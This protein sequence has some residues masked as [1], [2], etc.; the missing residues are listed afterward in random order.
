M[1]I[2]IS[3]CLSLMMMLASAA[4]AQQLAA[5]AGYSCGPPAN[6]TVDVGW[7]Q[8]NF[9]ECNSGY[10]PYEFILSPATVG[11]LTLKWST[12]P[13]HILGE[14]GE[15]ST[16]S[17][18]NG[19][20]YVA[21][22]DSSLYALDATTGQLVW[23]YRT[24]NSVF[25]S[26]AV[27]NNV[28]YFGSTDHNI[29]ALDAH[30]GTLIW[31]YTANDA[32]AYASPTVASGVVYIGSSALYA[33]DASTGALLWKF[34]TQGVTFTTPAVVNGI[35]YFEST[36]G[37]LYAV[38]AATGLLIWQDIINDLETHTSPAVANGMVYIGSAGYMLAFDASTGEGRWGYQTSAFHVSAPAVAN[39]VVYFTSFW[40]PYGVYALNA[41]TGELLWNYPGVGHNA[42]AIANGV[43]YAI[44]WDDHH[45]YALDAS[46]G[47]LLW[48][49]AVAFRSDGSPVVANGELYIASFAATMYA[50]GLPDR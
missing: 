38:E 3:C 7:P 28:V 11:D 29:Y 33:L 40:N 25:S 49:N 42:V 21:S 44:S 27:A 15:L 37:S 47:A 50:Y 2:R 16:P 43:I 24:G 31:K 30:T 41:D 20:V 32:F 26:P 8:F 1:K 22:R 17:V 46:T 48:K 35:V 39:G 34:P 13:G 12:T 14:W 45:V 6:V 4:V 5:S 23:K 36:D 10:N 18:A 9:D 19:M